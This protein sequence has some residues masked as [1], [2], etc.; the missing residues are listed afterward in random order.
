MALRYNYQQNINGLVYGFSDI[1][2]KVNGLVLEEV[3]SI[4]YDNT[5]T[6]EEFVGTSP[7]AIGRT[8]GSVSYKGSFT[9]SLEDSERFLAI[10]GSPIATQ[11]FT[12]TVAYSNPSKPLITD[13]LYGCLID[14]F[15]ES[16]SKGGA[17]KRQFNISIQHIDYN[18][19]SLY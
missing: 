17:I 7:E 12:I 10:L 1:E 13:T 19:K 4:S 2:L 14:G 18:G 9:M 8:S 5:I 15:S 16:A 11:D 6:R 3:E